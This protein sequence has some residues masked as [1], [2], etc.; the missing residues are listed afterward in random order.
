LAEHL[1]RVAL[2]IQDYLR[3]WLVVPWMMARLQQV[4]ALCWAVRRQV[5]LLLEAP[6]DLLLVE[7]VLWMEGRL[8]H[9]E[10]ECHR[11]LEAELCLAVDIRFPALP[12]LEQRSLKRWE[13]VPWREA[14]R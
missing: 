4:E 6:L 10:A 8:T 7:A 5:Q 13:V 12:L 2:L 3:D 11:C 1:R 14:G 9:F